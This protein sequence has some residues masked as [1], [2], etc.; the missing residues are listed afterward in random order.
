MPDSLPIP[1]ADLDPARM[2]GHW[3]LARL[4]KRVLRPG[5]RELTA[6]MLD[7]LA[8]G[9]RD[10]V[11]ELAP[12]LGTTTRLVLA[13]HPAAYTGVERDRAAADHVR[14]LSTGPDIDCRVGDAEDTGLDDDSATVVFGEAMLTMQPDPAKTRIVQEAARVLRPGG[15]YGIHELSLVP[16]DIDADTVARIRTELSQTI[17]IG[18][19]PLTVPEWRALLESAGLTV[20]HEARAPMR[21]LEP[22]RLLRDEGVRG[23]ARI[24]IRVASDSVA[25]RRVL[26][27]RALFRRYRHHLGAISLIAEVPAEQA[28]P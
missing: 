19:R 16:D 21:L 12:G 5:G 20:V 3:L 17:R 18:A 10:R 13:R 14:R 11:V 6:Q 2:P 15:R 1:G 9:P 7:A 4:G 24:L 23:L 25:R 8:I 22:S 28:T 27:M 26:E